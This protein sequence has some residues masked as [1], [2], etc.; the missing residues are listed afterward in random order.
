MNNTGI[1]YGIFCILSRKFYVG[2]SIHYDKRQARHI[3]ELKKNKHH[4]IKLQRAWNKYGEKY[5]EF[6]VL[7]ETKDIDKIFVAE[8]T[9]I[10]KLDSYHGGYNARKDATPSA[11]E[12]KNGMYKKIP[13]NKA[14]ASKNRKPVVSYCIKTGEVEF[15]DYV[16]QVSKIHKEI[17]PQFLGCINIDKARHNSL[18]GRFWF[19]RKDFNLNELKKRFDRLNAPHGLT[20]KERSKATK[21][22]IS[23]SRKGIVFSDSHKKNLSKAKMG[24]AA[25]RVIRSDGKVYNSIKS[26]A[27]DIGLK[28]STSLSHHLRGRSKTCGGFVFEYL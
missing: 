17:G 10:D 16:A 27:K 15:F 9:W 12:D 8:Q 28:S 6:L 25:K 26:A 21:D 18:H 11:M 24:E 4:S 20:G 3:S 14:V 23:K 19:Y 2:S 5:F 22:K 1:V 7:E 13:H